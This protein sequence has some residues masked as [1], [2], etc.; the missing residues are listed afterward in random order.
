MD[1]SLPTRTTLKTQAKRLRS[2]L[3]EQGKIMSHAQ[4]LET[5]ARQYGMRDWNT[6]HAAAPHTPLPN[7]TSW[8]VGQRVSG[9]YLD[10]PFTGQIKS[11]TA[12]GQGF[13]ALTVLFDTA[14][15]VVDAQQFTNW[16]KQVRC[17]VG[18]NGRSVQ[19]TSNGLP[20]IQI[21]G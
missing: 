8:Q 20:H 6:L 4:S 16:R 11:A 19:K 7:A 3:V 1:R 15:D 5:I 2:S 9:R 13:W 12:S 17:T 21:K 18:P 10:H 14:I